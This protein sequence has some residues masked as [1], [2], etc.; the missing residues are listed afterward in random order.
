MKTSSAALLATMAAA[1]TP[2]AWAATLRA[3][4]SGRSGKSGKSK[5]SK[6]TAEDVA[7]KYAECYTC[8]GLFGL[9]DC[10]NPVSGCWSFPTDVPAV[11]G[12]VYYTDEFM[13]INATAMDDDT[14]LIEG[15]NEYVYENFGFGDKDF[16]VGLLDTNTCRFNVAE[17]TDHGTWSGYF[18]DGTIHAVQTEPNI[19]TH[20][21]GVV[22]HKCKKIDL[23]D[24]E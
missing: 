3:S 21:G 1:S 14:L 2:A 23:E 16:F 15:F 11:D 13:E 18:E 17:T 12:T 9:P 24:V 5:P 6:C 20:R 4:A 7:G 19:G 10:V 22:T 8:G